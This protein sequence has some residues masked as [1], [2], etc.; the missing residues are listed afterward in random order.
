MRTAT[1]TRPARNDRENE[2][3]VAASSSTVVLL[4][5]VGTPVGS[6][7]GCKHGVAWYA[8]TLGTELLRRAT[9]DVH[10][11][12]RAVLA[13]SIKTVA[14]LHSR[15]CDLGHPGTPSATV[16]VTRGSAERLEYLVLADSVL[17]LQG[18]EGITVVTDDR[19]ARV[20]QRYR[21]SMDAL[22]SGSPAH[23]AA[24]RQY[25]ETL[26][27]FRNRSG[28]FWVASVDPSAAQEA[29][30]GQHPLSGLE[31]VVMLSDGAS[32]LVDR[33]EQASWSD[34]IA[35]AR[36]DSPDAILER[37]RRLEAE[38]P[39]GDRWPR[40]KASDDATVAYLAG[41]RPILCAPSVDVRHASDS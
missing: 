12:M 22:H 5:G 38:D 10:D 27:Q 13:E 4:D 29:I 37:V 11:D 31:A 14:D 20:G 35:L 25:V 9:D 2:D 28:G 32:R 36:Q 8:R 24:H 34:L 18:S 23:V 15:T 39:A 7:S 26:R 17:L 1:A 33:F 3:F 16:I 40:G 6:D 21:E 19:E 41:L 30:V